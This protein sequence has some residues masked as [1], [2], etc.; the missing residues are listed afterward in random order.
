MAIKNLLFIFLLLSFSAFSQDECDVTIPLNWCTP[1]PCKFRYAQVVTQPLVIEKLPKPFSLTSSCSP[2]FVINKLPVN[3]T[4]DI[5]LSSAGSATSFITSVSPVKMMGVGAPVASISYT[6]WH[7]GIPPNCMYTSADDGA[8]EIPEGWPLTTYSTN[9]P[10]PPAASCSSVRKNSICG[11]AQPRSGLFDVT[12]G[13]Y[14]Y[15]QNG[16]TGPNSR[17]FT[18]GQSGL[19]YSQDTAYD[20]NSVA[21]NR[22]CTNGYLDGNATYNTCAKRIDGVCGAANGSYSYTGA[23][24]GVCAAGTSSGVSGTWSWTCHGINNG[25]SVNCNIN[26]NVDCSG[27]FGGWSGC[28]SAGMQYNVYYISQ[29]AQGQGAQCPYPHGYTQSNSC[30]PKRDCVG[31]WGECKCYTSG[32]KNTSC[33]YLEV[34]SI[35]QQASGGGAGCGYANGATRS[36]YIPSWD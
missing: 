35:S 4:A 36:C 28:N 17:Y 29:Y 2:N 7:I 18:S 26:R 19:Y 31:S 20:C 33:S 1:A 30:V 10:L 23:G 13:N 12:P 3:S 22:V 32:W 34:F 24:A 6:K 8:K 16:C 27:Y 9:R 25:V 11:G 14:I 15:C 21:Q 5:A